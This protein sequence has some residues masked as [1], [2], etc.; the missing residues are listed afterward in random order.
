MNEVDLNFLASQ[1]ER[2][3]TELRDRL[4]EMRS[5]G[6]RS[7]LRQK[8]NAISRRLAESQRLTSNHQSQ[9]PRYQ[10]GFA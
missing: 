6:L 5:T 3:L 10:A 8:R 2:L 1:L 9:N 7:M 4:A